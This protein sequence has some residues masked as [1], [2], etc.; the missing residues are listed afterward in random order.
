M[1][2]LQLGDTVNSDECYKGLKCVVGNTPDGGYNCAWTSALRPAD[3][4]KCGDGTQVRPTI[5]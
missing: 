3:G 5:Q 2:S 1:F 4:T